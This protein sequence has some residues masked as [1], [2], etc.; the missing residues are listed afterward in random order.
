M[1]GGQTITINN[2][3][4]TSKV[5]R[6][7]G[8]V[9][10]ANGNITITISKSSSANRAILNAMAIESYTGGTVVAPSSLKAVPDTSSVVLKWQDRSD[11]EQS[12]EIWRS[13]SLSGAFTKIADV[14]ANSITYKDNSVTSNTRYFY[15]IRAKASG[16]SLSTFSNVTDATTS[17]YAVYI[18]FNLDNDAPAPWNNTDRSPD[19]G[20][21][22]GPF[23]NSHGQYT[24]ISINMDKNF[25]VATPAGAS[26]GNN[27]GVYP[28]VVMQN[29]YLIDK[30]DDTIEM[31]I[32]NLN[33]SMQYDLTFFGSIVTAGWNN[34]TLFII[35]GKTAALTTSYNSTETTSLRN[36]FPDGN[37]Q[38]NIKI[39]CTPESRYV[40]LAAMV[41]QVHNAYD[42]TGNLI[43]NPAYKYLRTSMVSNG[44]TI[45][46]NKNN[47]QPSDIKVL[48]VYP[49][50]FRDYV[51]IGIS[52]SEDNK[53]IFSLFSSNGAL[54]DR[55][56]QEVYKGMNT[57]ELRPKRDIAPGLY[58][59]NIQSTSSAKSVNIKLIKQ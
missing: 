26:T 13:Q 33:I 25:L 10:D 54:K 53:F 28:D 36:I 2:I 43:G 55:Q 59:L 12:F 41:I 3:R 31:H 34:T 46:T 38:I 39:P 22:Y 32:N 6:F 29:V 15:K 58:I 4:N 8:L 11:N 47:L 27:S 19:N 9:S 18:N 57:I 50:P 14:P 51:K 48:N 37:G 56:S 7:N 45:T 49:N 42:S 52:S 23:Y 40:V 1:I 30:G 44:N 35:N 20:D 5:A 21:A 17:Q 24:D 16:T